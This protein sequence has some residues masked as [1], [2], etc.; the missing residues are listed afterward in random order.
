MTLSLEIREFHRLPHIY[1]L[2]MNS[3]VLN[4]LYLYIRAGEENHSVKTNKSIMSRDLQHLV[5]DLP[6]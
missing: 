2:D 5:N 3:Y 6:L 4:P 1:S